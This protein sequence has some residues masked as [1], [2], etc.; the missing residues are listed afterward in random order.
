MINLIAVAVTC[1]IFLVA[2]SRSEMVPRGTQNLAEVSVDFIRTQVIA[3]GIG[4]GGEKYLPMLLSMFFFIFF[5]NITGIIPPILMPANARMANPLILALLAW[6]WFIGVGLKH[7]GIHYIT[8]ALFPPGVPKPLYLLV[9]PI[10]FVSTFL[11]R[12]FSLAVRLFAN[13]LA[14]HI[15][16]I[17]FG[18]LCITL[19][20]L[21]FL[22]AA[23]P[24]SLFMLIALTGFEVLVAF[25]QAYIFT[26]LTAVYIG[27]ALHPEH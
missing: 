4:H 23:L 22:V 7:H 5:G 8:G 20:S 24:L 18:V 19:W 10:E 17:T 12:P 16:L 9:T 26:I 25:L 1:G 11:V 14:G 15:L 13:L 21:S 6:I 27:G 2:R 3:P